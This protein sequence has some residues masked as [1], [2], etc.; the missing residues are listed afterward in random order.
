MTELCEK[1]TK[2]V[3]ITSDTVFDQGHHRPVVVEAH[4]FHCI[5]RLK[6]M[7]QS[8]TVPWSAIWSMAARAEADKL[9]REKR[10]VRR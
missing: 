4:P 5:V 10:A 9:A 2:T 8:Y 6:N 7:R 3:W 1:K